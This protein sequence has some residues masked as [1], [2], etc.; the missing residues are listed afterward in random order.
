MSIKKSN[1]HI[2]TGIEGFDTL[3]TQGIP[4]TSSTILAGGA[5]SG[6]TIF[7]L[8]ALA[9]HAAQ[10]KKCLYMSFEE[11]ESKLIG[12]MENFGWNPEKLIKSG[13]LKII[14]MN[15]FDIRRNIDALLTKQKGELLIDFNPVI[16]PEGF[17]PDL[18]AVD[19]LSAIDSAFAGKK[20]DYRIYVEQLFRFFEKIQ[21]SSLLI[22]ETK[23]I[24]DIFSKTGVE[25][26]LADGVVVLYNLQREN[27]R[28][29]ALEILKL[30]GTNHHKELVSFKITNKG[31]VVY[32]KQKVSM[33]LNNF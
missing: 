9:H 6:K 20:G 8:Q 31:I 29:R 12:H 2:F 1:N 21:S 4:K 19:S 18:I 33:L 10:G 16:I 22:T 30:R 17:K 25:E 11:P 7:C 23:Q 14:R 13:N 27:K 15:P 28:Q 5:G 32:P 26:F 24:P 3:L